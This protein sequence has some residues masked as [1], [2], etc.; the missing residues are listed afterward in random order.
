MVDASALV[1]ALDG[2]GAAGMTAR[3][4]VQRSEQH[5]PHLIDLEVMSAM[6]SKLLRGETDVAGVQAVMDDLAAYPLQRHA[7]V[8]LLPRVWQ[9][10]ENVT[11][12]DAVYIAL[13]EAIG[14]TLVTADARLARA[15]GPRCAIELLT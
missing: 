14:A 3:A 6:R 10:R 9:L 11:T 5:A 12:Y 1:A 8:D 13:T 7:H 15:P 2:T 4:A